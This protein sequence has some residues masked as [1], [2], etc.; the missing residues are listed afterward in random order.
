MSPSF[1]AA[2][3]VIHIIVDEG[4]QQVEVIIKGPDLD[5]DATLR[6]IRRSSVLLTFI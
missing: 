1:F 5:R 2:A 4:I 3:N 6:V